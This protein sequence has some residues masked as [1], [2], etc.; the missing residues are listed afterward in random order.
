MNKIIG[1]VDPFIN[2]MA[3]KYNLAYNK[4]VNIMR[5]NPVDYYQALEAAAKKDHAH[6]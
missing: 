4:V 3:K 2:Q 5:R 6:G 1:N